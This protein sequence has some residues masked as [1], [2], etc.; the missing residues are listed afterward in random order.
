MKVDISS[1][2]FRRTSSAD[3]GSEASPNALSISRIL[4]IAGGALSSG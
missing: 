1:K 4:R 3:L 2:N